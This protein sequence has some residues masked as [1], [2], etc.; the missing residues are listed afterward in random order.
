MTTNNHRLTTDK[1]HVTINSRRLTTNI[2]RPT[3][4]KPRVTTNNRC[5]TINKRRLTTNE[6]RVTTDN[7]CLTTNKRRLLVNFLHLSDNN[8]R[9]RCHFL[10][11]LHK[12][13]RKMPKTCRNPESRRIYH[14]NKGHARRTP[15]A[16]A[17][18]AS[19]LWPDSMR[20]TGRAQ[21]F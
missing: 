17:T 14:R 6:P 12:K 21:I 16:R 3:T 9:L 11:L 2:C 7:R 5:M 15:P 13:H 10:C 8:L 4:N 20:P 18:V 1:R 19:G